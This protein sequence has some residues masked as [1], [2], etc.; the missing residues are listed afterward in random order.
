MDDRGQSVQEDTLNS[1]VKA[2]DPVIK[3]RVTFQVESVDLCGCN[4]A[5]ER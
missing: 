3:V 4:S 5:N 1:L 2:S